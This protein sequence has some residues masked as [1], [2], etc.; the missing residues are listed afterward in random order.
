[1][2]TLERRKNAL[3]EDAYKSSANRKNAEK[4]AIAEKG[5]AAYNALNDK[6]RI[7]LRN[8]YAAKLADELVKTNSEYQQ[9]LKDIELAREKLYRPEIYTETFNAAVAVFKYFESHLGTKEMPPWPIY[10]YITPMLQDSVYA[11]T[12]GSLTIGNPYMKINGNKNM[13]D[14]KEKETLLLTMAHEY[15]HVLQRM[16]RN[17][18]LSSRKYDEATAMV[19]EMRVYDDFKAQGKLPTLTK[20]D[21]FKEY[22]AWHLFAMPLDFEGGGLMSHGT[23]FYGDETDFSSLIRLREDEVGTEA[24]YVAG[25]FLNYIFSREGQKSYKEILDAYNWSWTG[26][27][28][29]FIKLVEKLFG[30]NDSEISMYYQLFIR[31]NAGKIFTAI[32]NDNACNGNE[33]DWKWYCPTACSEAKRPGHARGPQKPQMSYAY[34]YNHNCIA[35]IRRIAADLPANYNKTFSLLIVKDEKFSSKLPDVELYPVENL[36]YKQSKYGLFYEAETAAN[37]KNFWMLELDTALAGFRYLHVDEHMPGT[38][39]VD[40]IY[41]HPDDSSEYR[42]YTLIAP[43]EIR[44]EISGGKIK[45]K[46]PEKSTAAQDGYIDGYK[47]T[48]TPSEGET[49]VEHLK[50]ES[51]GK[52]RS[53]NLTKMIRA[54]QIAFAQFGADTDQQIT[55]TVSV[56]EYINEADGT[57]TYG[58][59]SNQ[60]GVEAFMS[61]FGATAGRLQITL[62]WASTDDLDLHCLTPDGGHIYYDNKRAGGGYLEID[63]NVHG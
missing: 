12:E 17:R 38:D 18:F 26:G 36:K 41:G 43:N 61:A 57:R 51:A 31:K 11:T 10:L 7:A 19:V 55:F 39:N 6:D 21:A 24:G 14:P 63:K 8:Q 25:H 27:K 33:E 32:K 15:F 28:A 22:N 53:I 29:D 1:M 44:P 56:C 4:L 5:E 49:Y 9:V 54:D 35:R 40:R 50:I 20:A 34:L 2:K 13:N 62:H 3:W 46:L 16:R 59:E 48:I 58:P 42:I 60:G 30:I 23:I 52:E 47:V 37:Y 45:F